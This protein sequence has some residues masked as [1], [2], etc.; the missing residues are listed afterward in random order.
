MTKKQT[1][2]TDELQTEKAAK[3]KA[4]PSRNLA[5]SKKP[6]S[7][8]TPAEASSTA[9][10]AKSARRLEIAASAGTTEP[11]KNKPLR[12]WVIVLVLLIFGLVSLE[13][14]MLVKN[15]IDRHNEITALST[16]GDRGH[17]DNIESFLDTNQLKVDKLNRTMMVD[18]NLKRIVMW[19]SEGKHLVT[20]DEKQAGREKFIPWTV[21]A[22]AE[23]TLYVYDSA[24]QEIC[25]F[26][27]AFKL[28]NTWPAPNCGALSVA[29]DGTILILNT[30]TK[31]IIRYQPD[32]LELARYAKSGK[33]KKHLAN[34]RH[35][36][37]DSRGN[38]YVTDVESSMIK[39][40]SAQGKFNKAWKLKAQPKT[41]W[42]T[43]RGEELYI[44]SFEESFIWVYT[45][46][47]KLKSEIKTLYP[48][49]YSV[50]SEKNIYL[51]TANGITKFSQANKK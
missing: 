41:A 35:L 16:F 33:A 4:K 29:D 20:I 40:Y 10:E 17:P 30:D 43:I 39:K 6:E 36:D 1:K 44:N 48:S 26:S 38:I 49:C 25:T 45:L 32:G 7:P 5:A 42:L 22:D 14:Y 8:R 23:G 24:T 12:T 11:V 31:Q 3:K 13:T 28:V 27:K 19:D 18:R 51:P 47:G 9:L 2:K 50:D 37:T 46:N 21:D 34:P 15:K